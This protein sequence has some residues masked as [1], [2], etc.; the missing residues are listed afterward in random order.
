MGKKYH[1]E[2]SNKSIIYKV[3]ESTNGRNKILL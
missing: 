1:I 3:K 2:V